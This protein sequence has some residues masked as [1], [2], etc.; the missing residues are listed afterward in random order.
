[1]SPHPFTHIMYILESI[2]LIENFIK[3]SKQGLD[4]QLTHDAVLYRL[5]TLSESASKLPEDI[6]IAHPSVPWKR[7]F[8]TRNAI[9]HDYLG[10]IAPDEIHEFIRTQLPLLQSA[11]E[12]QLPEWR[13][14]RSRL[15]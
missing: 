5:Q 2:E 1:M 10:N 14:L 4:D 13:E 3:D 12:K 8:Y 15:S 6:K 9:V 11:M 7:F